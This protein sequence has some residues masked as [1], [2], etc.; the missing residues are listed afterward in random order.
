MS[1]ISHTITTS[2][3]SSTRMNVHYEFLDS[4]GG[5]IVIDKLVANDFD[6]EAYALSMYPILE[7]QLAHTE[8][9]VAFSEAEEERN[10]D[11]VA[12]HQLQ[13]DFDRRLLGRL[14]TTRNVHTF[15]AG[16]AF[17]QTFEIRGGTNK[18]QRSA[19]LGVPQ[20]EYDLVDKRFNDVSGVEFFLLDEKGRVWDD[21]LD[22]WE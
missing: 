14:M 1:I 7:K 6:T 3:Q 4:T 22:G 17:F 10:P 18:P 16:Y 19:Y 13:P 21:P 15:Y 9:I 11:K 20:E 2:P 8:V 12:Q 5:I